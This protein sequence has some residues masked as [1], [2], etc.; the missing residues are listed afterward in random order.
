MD[1]NLEELYNRHGRKMF[2]ISAKDYNRWNRILK[3]YP[4]VRKEL[5]KIDAWMTPLEITP[6]WKRRG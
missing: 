6:P 5:K 4:K 2:I 1:I 3:K